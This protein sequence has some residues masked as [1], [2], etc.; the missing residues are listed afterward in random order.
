M[1]WPKNIIPSGKV[2]D[3]TGVAHDA[4]DG[5]VPS[6]RVFAVIADLHRLQK[7]LFIGRQS[8]HSP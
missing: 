6:N 4:I 7:V 1:F 8:G 5:T 2:V 3:N